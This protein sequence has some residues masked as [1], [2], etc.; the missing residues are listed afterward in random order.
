ERM[1]AKA[2]HRVPLAPAAVALLQ[3][4]P[5]DTPHIFPGTRSG[6]SNI[7]SMIRV[8]RR[9]R[10]DVTVHGFRSTFSTW[11][12]E[13]PNYQHLVIEQSLSHSVGSAVERAYRRTDLFDKRRK[14][15]EAWAKHCEA[16]T[17]TSAV[18]PIRR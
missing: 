2:E 1:K 9:L 16:P 6:S 8:L 5:Q 15:M 13:S 14:L 17:V 10:D 4:L 3:S 12:T 7:M 11:A 18:I